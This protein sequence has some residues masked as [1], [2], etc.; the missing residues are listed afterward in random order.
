[1]A[2]SGRPR[3]FDKDIALDAAMQAF[4]QGGFDGTTYADL[5][6]ATGLH[7]Q[8]LSYVFG[9][10]ISLFR[11]AMAHYIDKRVEKA[12]AL[13]ARDL[14]VMENVRA[15]FDAWE[16]DVSSGGGRGCLLVRSTAEL[17]GNPEV[18][19]VLRRGDACLMKAFTQA[20]QRA[21]DSNELATAIP[22]EALARLAVSAGQGAML[23]A[24]ARRDPGISRTAHDAFLSLL[25]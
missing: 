14:P 18:E 16:A 25:T 11:H 15:V 13:L 9:E 12:A 7:R 21:Q 10:K 22:P 6:K 20:F 8:S 5:E 1:M 4:W 23:Q 3:S 19:G 2:N 17:G 24:V